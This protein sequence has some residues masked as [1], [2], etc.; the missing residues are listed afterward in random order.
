MAPERMIRKLIANSVPFDIFFVLG[1]FVALTS[2]DPEQG[3]FDR[4]LVVG[5][6]PHLSVEVWYWFFH[7]LLS[8]IAS[9]S[10]LLLSSSLSKLGA[11]IRLRSIK[12]IC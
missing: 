10:G 9:V 4:E 8:V 1:N 12:N 11:Q 5:E 2:I 7:A 6:R 3:I